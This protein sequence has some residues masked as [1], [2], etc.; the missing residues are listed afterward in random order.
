MAISSR[1]ECDCDHAEI[2]AGADQDF[3][4][5]RA[6]GNEEGHVSFAEGSPGDDDGGDDRGISVWRCIFL[7]DLAISN[8]LERGLHYFSRH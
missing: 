1:A 6:H 4:Q 8:T 5:R 2:L 3:L 7:V